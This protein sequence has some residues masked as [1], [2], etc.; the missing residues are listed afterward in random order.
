LKEFLL[1][2][3]FFPV[4]RHLNEVLD[5]TVRRCFTGKNGGNEDK[6]AAV[7]FKVLAAPF[8]TK[9]LILFYNFSISL[10]VL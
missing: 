8:F 3:F 2:F 9:A 7:N 5:R 1:I 4:K 10:Y 6:K